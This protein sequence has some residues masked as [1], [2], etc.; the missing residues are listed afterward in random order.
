MS[1]LLESLAGARSRHDHLALV[2]SLFGLLLPLLGLL[3]SKAVVPLVLATAG[4]AAVL[5]GGRALPWRIMDRP[6]TLGFGLLALWCLVASLWSF[7]PGE[8]VTL[9]LRVGVLLLVLIYLCALAAS[10]DQR[11]RRVAALGFA[12]G[13]ALTV[14]LV[15][16]EFSFGFPVSSALKG[17]LDRTA[18]NYEY[19]AY[20]RLNRG[21][22]ALAILV[23]PL[24]ALCWFRGW[25]VP[26]LALPPALFALVMASQ[27]S[28]TLLGF[29]LGILTAAIAA[30]GRWAGRLVLTLAVAGALLASPGIAKLMKQAELD[31]A[32]FLGETANFRVHI[33]GFVADRILERPAFGWGFDSSGSIPTEGATP[34]RADKEVIPSH[35][36]NGPLQIL[37]ELGYVGGA[38]TVAV[39]FLLGRKLDG[40]PAPGRLCGQAML[41]T[42]LVIASSAYSIWQSH[43]LTMMGAAAL[44]LVLALPGSPDQRKTA[45]P[46]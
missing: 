36:H 1:V 31:K 3:A 23:W 9:A 44:I 32:S 7:A 26:A 15:V 42:V 35:P 5:L 22:S 40:L 19:H 8:A 21:I 33:W 38:L 46:G 34:F 12:F 41:I 45:P 4:L 30:L 29:G 28:A 27:S 2:L 16:V 10:L 17:D 37:L 25:R 39:L 6:V 24:A 11:Q 20:S 18:F 14:V 43:W 13:M